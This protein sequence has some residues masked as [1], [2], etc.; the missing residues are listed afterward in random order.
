VALQLTQDGGDG[1]GGEGGSPGGVESVDRL[2][3]A[4]ARHLDE[5]VERLC[6]A[7]VPPGQ[8]PGEGHEAIPQLLTDSG[9]AVARILLEQAP[10]TRKLLARTRGGRLIHLAFRRGKFRH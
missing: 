10:L 5:V 2:H 1:E 3:Q 8:S 9:G 7:G 6:A 4:H